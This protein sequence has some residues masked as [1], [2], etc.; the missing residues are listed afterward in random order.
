MVRS[1]RGVSLP[2]TLVSMALFAS[3]SATATSLFLTFNH[4][5]NL[6]LK[7]IEGARVSNQILNTIE[8]SRM[9]NMIFPLTTGAFRI[10]N[11]PVITQF[12]KSTVSGRWIWRM[13]GRYMAR[14]EP[15][16][17]GLSKNNSIC[18]PDLNADL[19]Y[20]KDGQTLTFTYSRTKEG[21]VLPCLGGT[22]TL[23]SF[24]SYTWKNV[25]EVEVVA[26]G[27]TRL[28]LWIK[29]DDEWLPFTAGE[30]E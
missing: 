4:Y 26:S 22:A 9:A 7:G 27:S 12:S 23:E 5:Y 24:G 18:I 11:G 1:N 16:L 13:D 6:S 21:E 25:Q 15:Q 3:I 19:Y 10:P 2:E 8:S 28:T 17:Y 29:Y 30:I 20:D 14:V